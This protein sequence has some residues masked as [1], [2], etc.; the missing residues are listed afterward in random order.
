MNKI[1]LNS[2]HFKG[3]ADKRRADKTPKSPIASSRMTEAGNTDPWNWKMPNRADLMNLNTLKEDKDLFRVKLTNGIRTKRQ[4]STNMV[5]SD[6]EGAKPRIEIPREVTRQLFYENK[7]IE[8]AQPRALHVEL[9]REFNSL[10][11]E[12]IKGTKP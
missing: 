1:N 5:A 3:M 2:N 7:D 6:I 12:D 10:V 11:N 9:K 4:T 8:G